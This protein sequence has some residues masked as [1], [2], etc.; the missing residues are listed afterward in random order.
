MN[1][2]SEQR[3]GAVNPELARRIRLLIAAM[4]AHGVVVEVVQ[5][6]RTFAE[7]DAL[8]AQGRTRPG[9]VVTRARGGQ[10]NHNYK[11]A[12]DLCP[13]VNGQPNWN[14]PD[15]IWKQ[16]ADEAEKLG[17]EA[18]YHWKKF[19]DKPHVQLPGLS[20]SECQQLY[21]RGGLQAVE[22]EATRRL[23]PIAG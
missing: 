5:G 2:A 12:C 8:F 16:I 20:V 3:L 7:Q 17:L 15:A 19:Q 22:A 1:H 10:S 23:K 18:G 6:F 4:L 9:P 13:F 11:L 21:K 14:A